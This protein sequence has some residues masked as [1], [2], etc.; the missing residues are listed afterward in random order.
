MSKRYSRPEFAND[1][2]VKRPLFLLFG[3]VIALTAV[4]MA[5][6]LKFEKGKP[7]DFASQ[8]VIDEEVIEIIPITRTVQHA[9]I[10]PVNK[11]AQPVIDPST[12]VVVSNSQELPGLEFSSLLNQVDTVPAPIWDPGEDLGNEVFTFLEVEN[13]PIFPGCESFVSDD[14]RFKCFN[15]SLI[16]HVNREFELPEHIK[17]FNVSEKLYVEFIIEKDGSIDQAKILRGEDHAL[18]SEALRVINAL[19]TFKPGTLNGKPVRMSY[20]LPINIQT[21]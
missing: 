14:E 12:F 20:I 9:E 7:I 19:P 1:L 4:F 18:K 5:F 16:S 11:P 21:F 3:L 6:E 10:L 17:S 13:R 15:A 8:N 2:E